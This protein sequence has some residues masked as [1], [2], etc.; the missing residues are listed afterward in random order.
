MFHLVNNG[1][2]SLLFFSFKKKVTDKYS[3]KITDNSIQNRLK[4]ERL[5]AE[6]RGSYCNSSGGK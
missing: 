4:E 2:K 5:E 6:S 3:G 1:A